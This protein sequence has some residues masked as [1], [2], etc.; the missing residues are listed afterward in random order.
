MKKI[1]YLLNSKLNHKE[2][3]TIVL[4]SIFYFILLFF[5]INIF[6]ITH[7]YINIIIIISIIIILPITI[8]ILCNEYKLFKIKKIV[9]NDAKNIIYHKTTADSTTTIMVDGAKLFKIQSKYKVISNFN[10]DDFKKNTTYEL[11]GYISPSFIANI[12]YKKFKTSDIRLIML[13]PQPTRPYTPS[14]SYFYNNIN[15]FNFYTLSINRKQK[16]KTLKRTNLLKYLQLR[17]ET[18]S[19]HTPKIT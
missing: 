2:Q 17:L 13:G 1:L 4:N 11:T 14:Y 19:I 8:N 12:V 18:T 3:C 9:L 6:K 16:L 7:P 15:R 5:I 10:F